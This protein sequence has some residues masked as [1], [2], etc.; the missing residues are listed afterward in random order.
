MVLRRGRGYSPLP[1]AIGHE[2]ASPLLSVGADMKNTVALA[3][4]D[5]V[6]LGP[7]IGDLQ[8]PQSCEGHDKMIDT[9]CKLYKIEPD[10]IACD[11]HPDYRSGQMAQARPGSI[12]LVQHHYAHALACLLD[13]DIEAP[14]LAVVWD[15][16]GYGDDGTIW[17]GELLKITDEG[18]VRA[19][20]FRQF[21]LPGGAAAV[22]VPQRTAYGLLYQAGLNRRFGF[23][24]KDDALLREALAR[25]INCPLTSSVGRLFDAVAVLTGISA[26][27]SFEGEAAM[28]LEFCAMRSESRQSYDFTLQDDIIDWQKMLRQIIDNIDA[29][30]PV[31]DIARKF[32]NTLST[33]IVDVA[34]AV[35]EKR[36][37]LT[38]GCFQN[39]LLLEN[40]IA[41][42]KEAGFYP[43]WHHHIPPGDGGIAAGQIMAAIRQQ[44]K[45]DK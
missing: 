37:L 41:A 29:K 43:C 24:D 25:G 10:V 16:T 26:D 42:L 36:V 39:K 19:F 12:A 3:F 27:N 20:H 17:G 32:H 38:G 34:R 5:K 1:Y 40:A 33:I 6:I 9:L 22:K 28:A 45:E 23:S 30:V 21:P 8:T 18:Y 31:C 14:A 44:K 35:G 11:K 4:G 13:N 2:I 15:G 7:H